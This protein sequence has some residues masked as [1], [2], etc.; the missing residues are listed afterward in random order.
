MRVVVTGGLGGVARAAV[1][2]LLAAGHDVTLTDRQP[3][4]AAGQAGVLSGLP[5]R[6]ADL[7]DAGQAHWAVRG[8]DAVVH[9]AAIPDPT[10]NAPHDVFAN[11]TLST[12]NVVEASKADAARLV[13]LSSE[14]V[15][16]YQYAAR[17]F[18]P[19]VLPVDETYPTVPQ[20][21]YGLS[22]LMG[23]QIISAAVAG[24]DLRAV[25]L[26]PSW[27][28]YPHTYERD[29][30][31]TVRDPTAA[32][33]NL[34]SYTDGD[35]LADL[36]VRGVECDLPGHEVMFAVNPDNVGDRDLVGAIL[37]H[38][39]RRVGLRPGAARTGSAIDSGLAHR[40]LGWT[41]RRS[42]RDHIP[43]PTAGTTTSEDAMT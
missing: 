3:P 31:E 7:C 41:P 21:P 8:H 13:Y 40:L 26:R 10:Q 37:A 43:V 4:P 33:G 5:Y 2:Q 32:S 14:T 9:T 39:G 1:P 23:E 18:V 30:G 17:P 34:W 24:S 6:Q 25:S 12:F 28:Q 22:K 20:D 36:I 19:D 38:L 16:G 15:L 29:L 11:N 27:V 35:D 42:W